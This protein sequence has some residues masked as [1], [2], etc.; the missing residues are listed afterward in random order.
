MRKFL[1]PLLLFC[2]LKGYAQR[3]GGNPPSI[4]WNQINTDTLR[5]IF[6]RGLESQAQQVAGTVT[7]LNRHNRMSIGNKE[8]KINIVLQNRTVESN[9]FVSLSPFR[10]VFQITPP[11]DNF[12]LGSLNWVQ[13]L[14]LHEYRH[15]L[16]NMNFR[17]GI[18]KTFYDLFGE[19]GQ[20][21]VTNALIPDWFWEGDAVFMETALSDQGRGRLPSF[22]EPFKSLWRQGTKYS[23]AKIR[24]GSYRDMTPDRYPLGYMMSAYGRDTLGPY[25]WELAV[26][27]ALLNHK[28]IRTMNKRYPDH[29]FHSLRYGFYPL[30]S[31]LRYLTGTGIKGFYKK[32]LHYFSRQWEADSGRRPLT[33]AR[34][35]RENKTRSELNY[36]YPQ[37][38]GDGSLLAVKY[39]FA[40]TPSIVRVDPKGSETLVVRMGNTPDD[41]FS[42]GGHRIVW[43]ETRPSARWGWTDYSVLRVYD[44]RT[45]RTVTHGHRSRYFSPALSS[46]GT[47]IAVVEN[48]DR[49]QSRLILLDAASGKILKR[50]PN[51][52]RL[53]YT[54]PVFTAGDRGILAAVRDTL[55]RMA[56]IRQPAGGGPAVL[57]KGFFQQP[58]GPPEPGGRYVFFPAAFTHTV[59]LYALDTVT[60]KIRSVATRPLG[61]YSVRR[62]TAGKRLVFDEYTAKGYFLGSIPFDPETWKPVDSGLTTR[63]PQ[64]YVAGALRAEGGPITGQIPD[65]TYPVSRYKKASH[66]F[67]VHSWS[68]LPSYPQVGLYL[69]SQNILNTLQWAAGGG[70]NFNENSPFASVTA[71]YA[72]WFPIVSLGYSRT[73]HRSGYTTSGSRLTWDESEASAG[74]S[75]PLN[76]SR[77]RYTRS[78]SFGGSV[79]RTSLNFQ[80]SPLLKQTFSR[81][82]YLEGSFGFS[83]GLLSSIQ[84]IYPAFAQSVRL[85]YAQ[86][87]GNT[88]ARQLTAALNLF[89]PGVFKNHSLYLTGAFSRKDARRQY[90]FTD[91]FSYAS[92]YDDV[93]YREIYKLGANYQLPL[94]YPDWGTTW[95]YLLRLR[96][97]LF[98]DYSHADMLPGVIPGKG[99]YRS[100]GGTLYLDTRLFHVLNIPWGI[101]YSYL[102]DRDFS[103]PGR[104]GMLSV[105]VPVSFF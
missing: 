4:R 83:N 31:S 52:D 78:L 80:P 3:F 98:F 92:G 27:Q 32:S 87:V 39:G 9:G 59:Q 96:L 62:D 8:Q 70:Y 11:A 30:S 66:L 5:V 61:D 44:M 37:P 74:F 86:A 54:Y 43:T 29:P 100:V 35:I 68:F 40:Y 81:I 95:A 91:N 45:G 79:H 51:P 60:G 73:F 64:P 58:I 12:S 6:P 77:N 56:L 10:A 25:F 33:P 2:C 23:Y 90:K 26:Q 19:N 85:D 53:I 38:L 69:Q 105:V 17:S 88:Y 13:L 63:V 103:D 71:S 1:M 97:H 14:S 72:G 99:T 22:L 89:F 18:G 67:Y 57:L 82:T 94:A 15:A 46:D 36:R 55:G 42:Y 49:E 24:N 34:V 28:L 65:R 7:Y 76:L 102:L 50:F 93:P 104:K 101:R 16:Q 47:R 75:V 21:F 41:Y 20:A 84:Q 48:D